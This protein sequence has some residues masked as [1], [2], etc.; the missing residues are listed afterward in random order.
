MSLSSLNL[1]THSSVHC[2]PEDIVFSLS[3]KPHGCQVQA[4]F[5]GPPSPTFPCCCMSPCRSEQIHSHAATTGLCAN[6]L[7]RTTELWPPGHVNADDGVSDCCRFR[8]GSLACC[9]WS[10]CAMQQQ[11]TLSTAQ[12]A[13][14]A[15]H[16]D[17]QLF[18]VLR[19]RFPL[20]FQDH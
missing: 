15:P 17:L 1:V 10:R 8:F 3:D 2:T 19:N 12:Q 14:H 13:A 18:S 16:L 11:H 5:L 7:R 4:Q 6:S 9:C 20:D